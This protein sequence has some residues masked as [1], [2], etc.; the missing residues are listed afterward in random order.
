MEAEDLRMRENNGF[1][2]DPRQSRE[3]FWEETS[4]EGNKEDQGQTTL[5]K[6]GV[7]LSQHN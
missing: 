1:D 4:R 5:G 3:E 7:V 2:L 6:T